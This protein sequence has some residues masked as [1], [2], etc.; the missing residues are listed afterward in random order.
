MVIL[1]YHVVTGEAIVGADIFRNYFESATSSAGAAPP[2]AAT[3][4]RRA[5][6]RPTPPTPEPPTPPV[7]FAAFST[8]WKAALPPRDSAPGPASRTLPTAR[9]QAQRGWRHGGPPRTRRAEHAAATSRPRTRAYRSYAPS[10]LRAKQNVQPGHAERTDGRRANAGIG[11][12]IDQRGDHQAQ[13]DA[14]YVDH[15]HRSHTRPPEPGAEASC[16]HTET[17]T[18]RAG[19]HHPVAERLGERSPGRTPSDTPTRTPPAERPR[20]T[21]SR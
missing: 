5:A 1:P 3:Q 9:R 13:V 20:D 11:V 12:D 18:R 21:S 15:V 4:A 17:S 16:T 19:D 6:G 14:L 10:G 2:Q 8:T 7:R